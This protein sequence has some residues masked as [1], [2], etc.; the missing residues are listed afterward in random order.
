M[1]PDF[2]AVSPGY[3][4]TLGTPLILGRDF[5]ERDNLSSPPVAIVD[6][7]FV[8]QF[9]KGAN[10]LGTTFRV[11]TGPGEPPLSYQ[12]IGLTKDA[13]YY[14]LRREFKPAVFVAAAQKEAGSGDAFIIRSHEQLGPLLSSIKQTIFGVNTGLSFQFQTFHSQVEDSL[15]RERLM[16]TLSGFFGLLAAV[17]ATIGLYGVIS[18]MVARRRN[19]IGIRIALGADRWK[20]LGLVL[21]EA[22]RL[23]AIGLVLG[24]ALAVAA[25]QAAASM[26]YG[27]K[28]QDP[29]TI[30]I[31]VVLLTLVA[32]PASLLPARRA[33]RLEPMIAL[34][35]E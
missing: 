1:I 18:Y 29:L 3:F 20:V 32:V 4:K 2:N 13:K 12:I 8:N 27:L 30:V 23:V 14:N 19:E 17:L 11:V 21:G 10:P 7:S 25:A 5:D 26:L 6:E 28:P 15:L 16:A 22:G 24:I 35:E 9:L 34:R 33:A 31:A